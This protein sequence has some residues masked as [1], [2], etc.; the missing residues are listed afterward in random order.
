[1]RGLSARPRT[2]NVKFYTYI[3][4][5]TVIDNLCKLG[6]NSTAR[7]L[8]M[9][10][11]RYFPQFYFFYFNSSP[12]HLLRINGNALWPQHWWKRRHLSHSHQCIVLRGVWISWSFIVYPPP[13]F[14]S[15]FS[16]SPL[17]I[18]KNKEHIDLFFSHYFGFQYRN[19]IW[20]IICLLAIDYI[21]FD[22]IR[23]TLL[24]IHALIA[25]QHTLEIVYKRAY[26]FV[27]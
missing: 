27:N 26:T 19:I 21:F 20:L 3:R 7:N 17:F 8:S 14:L 9:E 16:S 22:N 18:L 6:I 2:H 25:S 12:A 24:N 11:C 4:R 10:I 15:L 23:I 5:A 13:P 1:M